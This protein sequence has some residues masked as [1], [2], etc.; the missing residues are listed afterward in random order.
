[1]GIFLMMKLELFPY[2]DWNMVFLPVDERTAAALKLPIHPNGN[3]PAF[4]EAAED[5]MRD[6]EAR[7]T[8]AHAE[9]G[10]THDFAAFG[11][12]KKEIQTAVCTLAAVFAE[13]YAEAWNATR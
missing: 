9:A 1:M 12:A 2:D 10:R 13:K 11:A 3:I 7:L 6:A 8:A 5:F 4:V